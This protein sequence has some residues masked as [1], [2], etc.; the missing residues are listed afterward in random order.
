MAPEVDFFFP[1]YPKMDRYWQQRELDPG[2]Y[3]VSRNN[4]VLSWRNRATLA[5]SRT[6]QKVDLEI[7]KALAPALNPLRYD[8]HGRWEDLKFAGYTLRT[9]LQLTGADRPPYIG[10][11]QLAQMP[12]GG[13]M[14]VPTI[15]QS[16][17]KLYMGKIDAADL[18]VSEHLVRYKMRAPG[19]HKLGVRAIALTGRAGYMYGH[20]RE[21]SLIIRN[22]NVNPSG[23]YVDTPL[24][25]PDN[26]G[27]AFQA[28][29]VNSGLGEFSEL[30]YHVPAIGS[31]TGQALSEDESQ[32]WA[33]RGP[34]SVV[35][36]VAQHLLTSEV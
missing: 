13:D 21:A 25:E 15:F 31:R 3:Q 6:G 35:R 28:C 2:R 19:E 18:I 23:E 14:L 20:G 17:P 11:W 32:L 24:Q 33:F 27:F 26:F 29:N 36:S 30:E 10:I 7:T 5:V 16:E 8:Q 9:S 12:H 34:E 4:G 22:F 1:D